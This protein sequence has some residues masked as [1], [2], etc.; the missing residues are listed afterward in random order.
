MKK[1]WPYVRLSYEEVGHLIQTIV[2]PKLTMPPIPPIPPYKINKEK[3]KV[4]S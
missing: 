2:T 3:K 4:E 1:Q